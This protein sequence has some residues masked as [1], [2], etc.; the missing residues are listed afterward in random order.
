[1]GGNLC[2]SVQA[3]YETEYPAVIGWFP[4]L[5]IK[6][7]VIN[8]FTVTG[9]C[10]KRMPTVSVVTPTY[11]RAQFLEDAVQSVLNQTY[12]DLECIVVDGGSTDETPELLDAIPDN[13]LRVITRDRP[14]GLSNARNVAIEQAVGEYILFLDDDDR[15][16]ENAIDC[17]LKTLRNQPPDCAG[18]YT[19]RRQ[20]DETGETHTRRITDG[21]VDCYP[22]ANI[23]GPSCTLVRA[24]VFDEIGLFDESLPAVEDADFWIRL[25]SAYHMIGLDRVLYERRLH[26]EQMTENPQLVIEG[27]LKILEKLDTNCSPHIKSQLHYS[28]AHEYAHL[29]QTA[30]ARS[31]LRRAIREYPWR[32][33][34]YY[35][36]WWLLFGMFGYTLG[37]KVHRQAYR[38]IIDQLEH[39][40][41]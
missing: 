30:T 1:M 39:S 28:I 18:V 27:N 2:P 10:R 21:R 11:N 22:H 32:L 17:L 12:T 25:F 35:Y 8:Q 6:Y 20:I 29:E 38:P 26:D 24:E 16:Y 37:H 3:T 15:L 31:Y 34:Y 14:R 19:A 40:R 7:S 41:Q 5:I 4:P 23:G 13:R 33:A 9:C 36:H